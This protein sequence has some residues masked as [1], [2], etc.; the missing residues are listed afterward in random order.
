[1]MTDRQ[2]RIVTTTILAEKDDG[3]IAKPCMVLDTYK[4]KIV[5]WQTLL[6]NV[7]QDKGKTNSWLVMMWCECEVMS[8]NMHA[9]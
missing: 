5:N 3:M 4:Y 7:W 2:V 1:M 8:V 9:T 6:Q